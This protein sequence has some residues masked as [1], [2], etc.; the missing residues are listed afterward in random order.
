[1]Q[2]D[3]RLLDDLAKV[4]SGALGTLQGVKGEVTARL[5]DQFERVLAN[6][7]LV[8]RE[9]FDAVKAMAAAA[10][11]ENEALAARLEAL[12]AQLAGKRPRR[13]ASAT[14][15]AASTAAKTAKAQPAKAASAKAKPAKGKAGSGARAR[16]PKA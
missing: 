16:R 4:A 1:M 3:N 5:R 14:A 15:K 9:E 10:R 7:D 6:L 11:S 8:T 12:E 2:T 13:A